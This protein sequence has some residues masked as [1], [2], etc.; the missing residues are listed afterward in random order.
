MLKW[1]RVLAGVTLGAYWLLLFGATHL[2]P[3]QLSRLHFRGHDK[4]LHFAA[5]ASLTLLQWVVRY[6]KQRPNPLSLRPYFLLVIMAAYGAIDEITQVLVGRDSSLFDWASDVA[7]A[8]AALVMLFV[9]RRRVHWLILYWVG[10]T[11]VIHWPGTLFVVLPAHA[12]EFRVAGKI[13]AYLI[14][15]LLWLRML[16]NGQFVM[17]KLVFWLSVYVLGAYALFDYFAGML[18][19]PP[20]PVGDLVASLTAI[21]IGVFIVAAAA[22]AQARRVPDPYE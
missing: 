13:I 9:L 15:T 12:A 10:M 1:R 22:A 18:R 2:S 14:L 20:L 3:V 11:I 21:A 19:E 8:V 6:G 5:F 16:S 4:V 17:N 7:G